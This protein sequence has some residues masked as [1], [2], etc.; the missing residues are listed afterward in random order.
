[1]ILSLE[2]GVVEANL[3]PAGHRE[4]IPVV[5]SV[6]LKC[7]G[8][9]CESPLTVLAPRMFDTTEEAIGKEIETW[10]LHGLICPQGHTVSK[11]KLI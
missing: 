10:T 3:Q 11:A 9:D 6:L 2:P 7:D 4:K 8:L 5:F 1:M